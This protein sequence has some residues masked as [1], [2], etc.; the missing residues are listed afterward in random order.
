MEGD[1]E[2]DRQDPDGEII[3][4]DVQ[5]GGIRFVPDGFEVSRFSAAAN[6]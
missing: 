6:R 5:M 3:E 1:G 2:Q 4:G